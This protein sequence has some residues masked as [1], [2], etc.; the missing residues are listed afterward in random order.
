MSGN[1]IASRYAQALYRLAGGDLKKAKASMQSLLGI[2]ELFKI[3]ESNR[4]LRSPIMPA[5][6]KQSLFNAALEKSNGT[7]EL[8]NFCATVIS[9]GRVALFPHIVEIYQSLIDEAEGRVHAHLKSA[10]ELGA[11]EIGDVKSALEG[12]LKK[13]VEIGQQVDAALLGGFVVRIGNLLVDYSVKTKLEALAQNAV[14]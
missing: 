14:H 9:S 8:R 1:R 4:V 10:V 5:D 7:E 6:L 13:K 2:S 11:A 3:D 12:V